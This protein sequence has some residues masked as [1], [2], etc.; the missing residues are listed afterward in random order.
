MKKRKIPRKLKKQQSFMMRSWNSGWDRL[1]VLL[2]GIA[3]EKTSVLIKMEGWGSFDE[4]EYCRENAILLFCLF[5]WNRGLQAVL[6][7]QAFQ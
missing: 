4:Y 5:L 2:V 1:R 6:C 7:R 3:G